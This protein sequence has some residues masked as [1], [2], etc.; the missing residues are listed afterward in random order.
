[1]INPAIMQLRIELSNSKKEFSAQ[2]IKLKRLFWELQRFANPYY[3]SI[4]EIKA[5]EI[6]QCA[7]DMTKTKNF[8]LDLNKK[9]KTLKE[10]LGETDE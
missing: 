1:M 3:A 4:E 8:L 10:E 2:E 7:E 9:I 6:L 5:D